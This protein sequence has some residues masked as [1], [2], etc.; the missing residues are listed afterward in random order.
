M[1]EISL[2]KNY[3]TTISVFTAAPEDQRRLFEIIVEGEE[4][5]RGISG[6]VASAVHLSHD[7][8]RVIGYAQWERKEDFEAMRAD[9][10]RQGHFREVRELVKGVD[11]IACRVAFTHDNS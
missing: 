2:K 3:F 10:D 8:T 11:L 7:G 1:P 9:P 5:L 6:L 4:K